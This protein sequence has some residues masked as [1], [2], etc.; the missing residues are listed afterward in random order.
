[1]YMKIV[2]LAFDPM[3]I[4]QE[5]YYHYTGFWCGVQQNAPWWEV[6]GCKPLQIGYSLSE[7]SILLY[8]TPE[9]D[10]Y[11]IRFYTTAC[12]FN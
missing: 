3:T 9:I 2:F 8:T 10:A 4:L 12:I 5:E 11:L 6:V 1:M 7:G